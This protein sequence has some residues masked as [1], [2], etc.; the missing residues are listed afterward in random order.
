MS[1][2]T[3]KPASLSGLTD[4][5]AKEFH[6]IFMASFLAFT[7]IAILAHI[8]V[9]SWRPWI[10]GPNGYAMLTSHAQLALAHVANAFA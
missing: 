3:S 2:S 9:W 8:L 4:T 6:K 10:P 7:V 1:S 5:E